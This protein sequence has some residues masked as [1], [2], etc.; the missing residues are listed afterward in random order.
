MASNVMDGDQ[1]STCTNNKVKDHTSENVFEN[2]KGWKIKILEQVIYG[3]RL[4]YGFAILCTRP[5]TTQ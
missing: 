4:I 5:A 1:A 2:L 3:S